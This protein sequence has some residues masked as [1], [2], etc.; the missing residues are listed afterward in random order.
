MMRFGLVLGAMLV[1]MPA[2]A[3]KAPAAGP[4]RDKIRLAILDQCVL[5]QSGKLAAEGAGPKCGCYARAMSK[6]LTDEE[7]AGY[8]KSLP[9]RLADQSQTIFAGCK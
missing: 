4:T 2:M 9:K 7:V 3:Q 8:R 6:A 5:T 1:A